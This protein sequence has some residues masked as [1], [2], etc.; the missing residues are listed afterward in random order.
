MDVRSLFTAVAGQA[1]LEIDS[2]V[3]PI[4]KVNLADILVPGTPSQGAIQ[5]DYPLIMRLIKPEIAIQ[6]I[7]IERSYAPYGK[8]QA[9]MYAII[10]V[11]VV[12][13]GLLGAA[14]SWIICKNYV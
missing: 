12:A 7:G 8:P 6:A 13:A 3:T 2:N 1:E 5:S 10:G 4:I 11:S 9:G 14:G